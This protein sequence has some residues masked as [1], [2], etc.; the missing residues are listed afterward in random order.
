MHRSLASLS[1]GAVAADLGAR[2]DLITDDWPRVLERLRGQGV[3][4]AA[5]GRR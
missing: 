4:A 1:Y 5:A 2:L 3:G